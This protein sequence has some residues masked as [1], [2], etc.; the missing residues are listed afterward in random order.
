MKDYSFNLK[1][2]TAEGK[3]INK[4]ETDTARGYRKGWFKTAEAAKE[5]L[6]REINW[7]NY[8]GET[9]LS[10]EVINHNRVIDFW[11]SSK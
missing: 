6:G 9:I 1:V 4:N 2:K 11:H 10:W 7:A 8:C 5:R 3:I